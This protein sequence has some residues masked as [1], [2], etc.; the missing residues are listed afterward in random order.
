M[1]FGFDLEVW[2]HEHFK[3]PLRLQQKKWCNGMY[4]GAS[5]SGKS[6]GLLY[7]LASLEPCDLLFLDFK[8]DYPELSQCTN[9]HGGDDVIPALQQYYDEF[10]AIRRKEIAQSQQRILILEEYPAL[11]QYVDKKCGDKIKNYIQ[12]FLMLGRGT[13]MGFGTWIVCQRPDSTLFP[14]GAKLNF[15]V[16]VALGYMNSVD[17][18]V[19]F[20]GTDSP[21]RNFQT[22]QGMIWAD[23]RGES[24]PISIPQIRDKKSLLQNVKNHLNGIW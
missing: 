22:G 13:G 4:C 21:M 1:Q 12:E 10:Q 2:E 3:F 18:S 24:R 5:G 11:I 17:W 19:C 7:M 16:I 6:I 9:Y 8:A 23:G 14:G 15:H 20:P